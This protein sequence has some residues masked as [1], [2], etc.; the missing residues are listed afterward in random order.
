VST[1]E[2]EGEQESEQ[3]GE[4]LITDQVDDEWGESLIVCVACVGTEQFYPGRSAWSRDQ[5][6]APSTVEPQPKDHYGVTLTL[7]R[8]SAS[9][10]WI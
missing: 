10:T 2:Q 5:C 6:L 4:S 1:G 7:G 3:S 8:I 9:W